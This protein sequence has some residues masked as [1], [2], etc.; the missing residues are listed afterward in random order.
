M[1]ASPRSGEGKGNGNGSG[2]LPLTPALSRGERE[3][4]AIQTGVRYASLT[5]T[6]LSVP[7][8][9]SEPCTLLRV[10]SSAPTEVDQAVWVLEGTDLVET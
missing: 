2:P 9:V 7:T 10:W 3:E 4:G 8:G 5:P 1:L 6:V